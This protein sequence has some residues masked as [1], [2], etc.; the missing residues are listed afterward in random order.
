MVAVTLKKQQQ[1]QILKLWDGTK[2]EK[3]IKN[4]RDI[5]ERLN[6]PRR[7]VASVLEANERTT[8]SPTIYA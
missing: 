3:G 6:I 4:Y 1:K 5:G 7:Q 2:K 8:Y